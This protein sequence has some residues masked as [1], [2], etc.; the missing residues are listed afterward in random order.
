MFYS[1]ARIHQT[2]RVTLAM[3]AGI[4]DHVWSINEEDSMEMNME[5]I[6]LGAIFGLTFTIMIELAI[7]IGYLR[8]I[9]IR[10]S[11]N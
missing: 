8:Q 9:L 4:A 7:M 3:Q 1:F 5:M 6:V 10:L 11:S 2:L